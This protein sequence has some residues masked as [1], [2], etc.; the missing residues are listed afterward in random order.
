MFWKWLTFCC[1]DWSKRPNLQPSWFYVVVRPRDSFFFVDASTL[2]WIWRT[3]APVINDPAMASP[4][5]YHWTLGIL[6]LA[7]SEA[8][9][10]R[11]DD[12]A[13]WVPTTCCDI[14][15]RIH[16]LVYNKLHLRIES[17]RESEACIHTIHSGTH[18]ATRIASSFTNRV[19]PR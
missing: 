10:C 6:P 1:G 18:Y 13:C 17:P 12:S 14:A 16:D 7:C 2:D 8:P 3:L 5:R 9:S 11:Y 19:Q 4:L 15:S